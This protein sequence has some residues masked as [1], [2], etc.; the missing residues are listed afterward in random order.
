MTTT[1]RRMPSTISD[2]RTALESWLD[3]HR[4]T[5]AQK[6]AGLDEEQLREASV[7]PS[8]LSLMGLVRH[9]ADVERSW[10]RRCLAREDAPPIYYS[11]E[12]LDGDINVTSADSWEEA[13]A[14]WQAE[15]AAA[16]DAARGR[17][18]DD[19]GFAA[20]RKKEV[21][22]RWIYLHM[23]E[24][25]ARHNGHADLIRERIDGATGA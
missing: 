9:M 5:L 21:D 11:D 19:L 16:R 17:S 25:Y 7:P 22:L 24:E 18:L 14:T 8:T 23:I 6:V 3:F 2:E 12:D 15:I 1:E 10:F 13:Y 4:A 20:H